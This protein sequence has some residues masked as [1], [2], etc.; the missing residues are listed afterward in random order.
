MRHVVSGEDLRGNGKSSNAGEDEQVRDSLSPMNED[1][2]EEA[3]ADQRTSPDAKAPAPA[4]VEPEIPPPPFDNDPME[5][6]VHD[7]DHHHKAPLRLIDGTPPPQ[8]YHSSSSLSEDDEDDDGDNNDHHQFQQQHSNSEHLVTLQEGAPL[9]NTMRRMARSS[10]RRMSS[11]G[12]GSHSSSTNSQRALSSQNSS[13]DWGWF[14]GDLHLDENGN[15]IPQS[16]EK[17]GNK[18][19]IKSSGDGACV[20]VCVFEVDKENNYKLARMNC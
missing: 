20:C 7:Y 9:R 19:D 13:R 3:D 10:L 16:S 14:F 15:P 4:L 18:G 6:V 12:Q 1:R 17:G 11:D 5:G 2:N 8:H